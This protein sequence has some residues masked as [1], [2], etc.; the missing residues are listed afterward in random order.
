MKIINKID[1]SLLKREQLVL[2]IEH[3]GDKTPKREEILEKIADAVKS[4]KELIKIKIIDTEFGNAK[5]TVIANVY[6]DEEAM[7]RIE[8]IRKKKGDICYKGCKDESHD[9][10]EKLMGKIYI[11]FIT[12]I[13]NNKY[14]IK[15]MANLNELEREIDILERKLN[16]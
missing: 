2:E 1:H 16:L 12:I 13:N 6:K 5:S 9:Y 3:T 14:D 4:K 15:L 8:D 7:K 10:V 11:K